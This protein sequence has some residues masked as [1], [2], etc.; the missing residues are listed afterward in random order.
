MHGYGLHQRLAVGV[1]SVAFLLAAGVPASQAAPCY[2]AYL[3]ALRPGH[4]GK[5]PSLERK[6]QVVKPA[7]KLRGGSMFH[8]AI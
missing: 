2:D 6:V 7:K 4:C 1:V 3:D 8:R 5:S